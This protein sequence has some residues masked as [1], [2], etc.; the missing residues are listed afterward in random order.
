M[1]DLKG[2]KMNNHEIKVN[3][4]LSHSLSQDGMSSLMLTP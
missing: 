3:D 4:N 1:N 2:V